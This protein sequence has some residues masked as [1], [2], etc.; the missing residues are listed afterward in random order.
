MRFVIYSNL[1][2]T[3]CTGCRV[4]RRGTLLLAK[5]HRPENDPM[6]K[7]FIAMPMKIAAFADVRTAK[8]TLK[9]VGLAIKAGKVSVD[10]T[11]SADGG[12]IK[13]G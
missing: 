2:S 4:Y 6:R 13:E 5:R 10:L 1:G 3:D 9:K 8:N 12:E 11:H 7:R